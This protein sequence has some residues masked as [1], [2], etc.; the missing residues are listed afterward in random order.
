MAK[1]KIKFRKKYD[2]PELQLI[3]TIMSYLYLCKDIYFKVFEKYGEEYVEN[4]IYEATQRM[5][6]ELNG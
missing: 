4:E 2:D 6:S 5:R 1:I 3:V